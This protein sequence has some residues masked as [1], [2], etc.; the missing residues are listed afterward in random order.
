MD[1]PITS[2]AIMEWPSTLVSSIITT[3]EEEHTVAFIGTADGELIKVNISGK[4]LQCAV[5]KY[6]VPHLN[7]DVV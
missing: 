4:F 7:M 3:I 5:N 2:T 6:Y 1:E